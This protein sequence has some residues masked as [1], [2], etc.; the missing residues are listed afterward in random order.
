MPAT[1]PEGVDR[2][3]A[4]SVAER[5]AGDPDR[6]ALLVEVLRQA[7]AEERKARPEDQARVDLAR[8]RDHALVEQVP[9]L[10]GERL[11][12]PSGNRSGKASWS[13]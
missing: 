10:V 5:T 8:G 2:G 11:Q 3:K 12:D 6:D 9:G 13:V 4:L 1:V 7:A